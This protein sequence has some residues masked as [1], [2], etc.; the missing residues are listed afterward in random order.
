MRLDADEM[1]ANAESAAG[2]ADWGDFDV[3]GPFRVLVQALNEEAGL[4]QRG[5]AAARARLSQALVNRLTTV[6]HLA[7]L[8]R[9]RSGTVSKPIFIPGLPRSGTTVLLN[10]LS[11]DGGMR[12]LQMWECVQ[13]IPPVPAGSAEAERRITAVETALKQ[14]GFLAAQARAIHPFGAR[15][16]EEC[17]FL[18]EQI[19]TYTPYPA[20]WNVPSYAALGASADYAAVFA[21]HRSMLQILQGKERSVRWVLKA[22]THMLHINE[23]CSVYPDAVFIQTHRDPAQVIPSLAKLFV[24]L[25]R[26]FSDREANADLAAAARANVSMWASGLAAMM[27][28]REDPAVDE[29][30]VDVHYTD[31]L[32]DP[33]STLAQVYEHLELEL[34]AET[35]A[36]MTRWLAD[37]HRTRHGVHSYSLADCGL[38]VGEIDQAFDDYLRRFEV[39]LEAEREGNG[40]H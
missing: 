11:C 9:R 12:S 4:H 37:N 8:Q 17:I 22:P 18:C 40:G 14:Q 32:S 15:L 35:E 31:L 23:I 7:R 3:E 1:L 34:S 33:L 10:L 2:L 24:V 28:T 19:M 27:K 6:A 20:F 26:L 13:P 29:R 5:M 16:A 25:R 36:A 30:F 38:S 39:A 21:F